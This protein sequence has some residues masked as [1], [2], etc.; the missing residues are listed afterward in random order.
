MSFDGREQVSIRSDVVR[1]ASSRGESEGE[2][3]N[4][5]DGVVVVDCSSKGKGRKMQ[6]H[7]CM[8]KML[9]CALPQHRHYYCPKA[10]EIWKVSVC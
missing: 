10:A 3:N 2:A 6:R 1:V 8:N 5:S 9:A 7:V 4:G